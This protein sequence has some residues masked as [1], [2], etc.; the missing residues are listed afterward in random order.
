LSK[1]NKTNDLLIPQPVLG[2]GG[3][4]AFVTLNNV[5]APLS[6]DMY[7]P[8]L[9]G[10]AVYFHTTAKVMNMTMVGFFF[11]FAIGML[12]FG[13]VSD[14][15]GRKRVLLAGITLYSVSCLCCAFSTSVMM[16]IISRIFQALG[17]GAMVSVSTALVKD[18]FTG[19]SQ[20]SVLAASQVFGVLAPV[21]APLIGAQLLRFFG[22]RATFVLLTIIAVFIIIMCCLMKETLP[23]ENRLKEN[24]IKSF[25]RL[26]VVLKNGTF[27]TFLIAIVLT[28]IPM[29]AYITT[30][31]YIYV[32]QFGL[33]TT[34]YSLF[35]AGNSL[36]SVIGPVLYVFLRNK[37]SSVLTYIIFGVSLAC[38]I[39]L[40][41][42]GDSSPWAFLLCFAPSMM[43][44]AGAR[45]FSTTILLNQQQ[46]DSGSASALINFFNSLSGTLGMAVITMIWTDYI[47]GVGTLLIVT[48][49]ISIVMCICLFRVKGSHVLDKKY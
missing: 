6:T 10:M 20:G 37:K 11:F 26:G 46:E 27:A 30:S 36:V 23:K 32:K 24:V 21:L 9:P 33:S 47:I 14:K 13:P 40:L 17:G 15:L 45:P 49:I 44:G 5:V 41:L 19:R 43:A 3:M 35:F 8:A 16:L 29:M 48:S 31:S 38:G 22:W 12:I 42:F 25:S 39:L 34:I 4:I 1:D 18:Q 2:K 28:Q 7:L